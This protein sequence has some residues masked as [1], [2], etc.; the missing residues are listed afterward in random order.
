[1]IV[2]RATAADHVDVFRL[3]LQF[4]ASSPHYSMLVNLSAVQVELLLDWLLEDHDGDHPWRP[5]G[6]VFVLEVEGLIIGFLAAMASPNHLTGHLAATEVALY[7]DPGYRL[8]RVWRD[9]VEAFEVWAA[10]EGADTTQL[11]EPTGV[12]VGRLYRRCGYVPLETVWT[13]RLEVRT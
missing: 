9:L 2:R 13:R 12:P 4:H 1:M 10:Q 7:V 11:I 5:R 3:G 8:G 6:A